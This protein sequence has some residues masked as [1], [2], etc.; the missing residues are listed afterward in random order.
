MSDSITLNAELCRMISERSEFP[1]EYSRS[2]ANSPRI[3]ETL[4]C[5]NTLLRFILHHDSW[6]GSDCPSG[7]RGNDIPLGSRIFAVADAFDAMISDRPYRVAL[8]I[9]E[10][11]G[12][13]KRCAE[14]QFDAEIFTA[15]SNIEEQAWV[16]P[17][18]IALEKAY[19]TLFDPFSQMMTQKG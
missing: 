6:D 12:E 5:S 15:F 11:C 17:T 9:R 2:Q 19:R 18:E 10:A 3:G 13:I 1:T 8:P 16:K 7:L 4:G 14:T